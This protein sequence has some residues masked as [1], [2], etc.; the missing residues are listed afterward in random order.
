MLPPLA[1]KRAEA[2][3]G[4]SFPA[5]RVVIIGDTPGDV[6]CAQSIRARTL[7]VATG[8]FTTEQLRTCNP[9]YVFESLADTPSVL[10]AIFEDG[11]RAV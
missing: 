11:A 2:L 3:A 8:P 6:A 10:R 9:T 5:E 4:V 1:L 7:A